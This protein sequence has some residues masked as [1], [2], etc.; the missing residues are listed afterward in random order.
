MQLTPSRTFLGIASFAPLRETNNSRKGAKLAKPCIGGCGSVCIRRLR[1]SLAVLALVCFLL[2]GSRSTF[3]EP[4]R[5]NVTDSDGELLP[6]RTHLRN[7][8]DEPQ[9]VPGQ[10]FWNDHFVCSGRVTA[11]L[12]P[13]E[14]RYE[15]ERGPEYERKAGKIEVAAG[16][17]TALNLTLG[18]IANLR[19]DGWYSADLH[20]HRPLA[21]VELLMQAEDLDVAPVITWWNN[22]NLWQGRAIPK[23]LTRSF[24]GHRLYGLMAGEDEREGGALLFFGLDRPLDISGS[25]REVP[26]PMKFVGEARKRNEKVWIDIEKPFWWDVPVWLADGRMNSIGL[27]NNHMCRSRMLENEAWGK[28]RDV[29]RLPNPRGNGFWTQAIYYHILNS[30]LRVPPSAGSAS[31][32]LPNPVGY[33]RVY[34]H[35]AEPF[36]RDAWFAGLGRGGSF[37]TN[38]PLLIVRANRQLPGATLDVGAGKTLEVQ[39]EIELTSIDRVPRLEVIQNGEVVQTAECSGD[40]TQQ[41]S[42][43]LNV[44]GPG[45]FLVR[46]VADVDETFRFASTAPWF[47]E[48]EQTKHRIS[49][50]SAEFFLDWVNERIGRVKANVAD[51]AELREVLAWHEKAQTFWEERVK[52]ANA[53]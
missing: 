31:G 13:G 14:Y 48:T 36:T 2:P 33:N 12:K 6:C 27:A 10:P 42:L 43:K 16:K 47:V 17:G 24:D 34:V 30:G 41:R 50:R 22:R 35:L 52:R 5:I 39:L 28:P 7:E 26:S 29:Q 18:R 46:A 40:L 23:D 21:D 9:R 8:K 15:I 19:K 4:L 51:E 49:R 3:A 38:G 20:V 1:C 37:V 25:K 32:V 11:D 45:W 53:D 44:N